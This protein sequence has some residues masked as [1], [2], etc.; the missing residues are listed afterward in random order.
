M[1]ID[2]ASRQMFKKQIDGVLLNFVEHTDGNLA[3]LRQVAC[4]ESADT[5][6]LLLS[7]DDG[8]PRSR[9]TAR[10]PG[11]CDKFDPGLLS[12]RSLCGRGR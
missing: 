6:V 10:H 2:V 7:P 1:A 5:E 8:T 12:R 9:R 4:R 11:R 3:L